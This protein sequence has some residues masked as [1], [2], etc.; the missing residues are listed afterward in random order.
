MY[1][2]ALRAPWEA[3]EPGR[4][5]I[6]AFSP[7]RGPSRPGAPRQ[8]GFTLLEVMI[9]IVVLAIVWGGAMGSQLVA[10]DMVQTGRETAIASAD[11]QA[12]MERMLLEPVQNLPTPGSAFEH[13]QPVPLFE[14]LHLDGERIVATYP[15]YVPGGAVPDPLPIL[16]TITWLDFKGRPRTMQL[17]SMRVR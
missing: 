8:G 1:R 16:L 11:L 17:T 6:A 2:G 4:G 15:G 10:G 7:R 13:D 12:C 9:A 14:G 3:P 5:R